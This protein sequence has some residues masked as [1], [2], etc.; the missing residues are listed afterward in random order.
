MYPNYS[1]WNLRSFQK[2]TAPI[3]FMTS[4]IISAMIFFVA[5][6]GLSVDLYYVCVN[7]WCWHWGICTKRKGSSTETWPLT[8]SCW[9]RTTKS[10]SVSLRQIRVSSLLRSVGK[11]G[12]IVTISMFFSAVLFLV[13]YSMCL[14]ADFQLTTL[15]L[16][17]L[18]CGRKELFFLTNF[19][20]ERLYIFVS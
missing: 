15:I 14:W 19:H 20:I 2:T 9:A 11:G 1:R 7:R 8:T 16:C 18:L 6:Y 17:L 3:F 5:C 12:D 10:P 4:L 13:T